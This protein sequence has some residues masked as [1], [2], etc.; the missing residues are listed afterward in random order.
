LSRGNAEVQA[1]GEVGTVGALDGGRPLDLD[2]AV[3]LVQRH[4]HVRVTATLAELPQ[5]GTHTH[6]VPALTD[7]FQIEEVTWSLEKTSFRFNEVTCSVNIAPFRFNKVTCSVKKTS[8]TFNKVTCNVK[9]TSFRFNNVTCSVKK[10]FQI[11][12]SNVQRE[13]ST[14]Q[15]Q[16]SNVQREKNLSDSTK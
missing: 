1:L 14:F 13:N 15:I 12:Q 4:A 5:H 6:T 9:K 10:I 7:N 11:Q 8:F 16:Q 3:V 2:G